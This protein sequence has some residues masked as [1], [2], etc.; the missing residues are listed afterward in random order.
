MVSRKNRILALKALS[1][2]SII[3]GY[4]IGII[5]LAQYLAS[6]YILAPERP[7]RSV[8]FDPNLFIIVLCSALVIAGD[9]KVLY[10]EYFVDYTSETVESVRSEVLKLIQTS[11]WKKCTVMMIGQAIKHSE[12]LLGTDFN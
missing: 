9:D 4:N 1:L 2:I 3:R 12:G 5:A 8:V 6:V 10:E 7:L 11:L